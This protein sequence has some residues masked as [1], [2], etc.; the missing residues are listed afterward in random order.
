MRGSDA[1]FSKKKISRGERRRWS[2]AMRFGD[3]GWE[4]ILVWWDGRCAWMVNLPWWWACCLR[5]F[6]STIRHCGSQNR[7]IST[8]RFHYNLRLR[9]FRAE[10]D[11][12]SRYECSADYGRERL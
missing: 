10:V 3:R 6:I 5:A 1:P 7:W 9:C 8:S 4:R 12:V 11:A 2:L